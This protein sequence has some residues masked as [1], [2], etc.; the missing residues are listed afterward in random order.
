MPAKTPKN[1]PATNA[2][3]TNPLDALDQFQ[4]DCELELLRT[5][6]RYARDDY[7]ASWA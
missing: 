1:A 2:D 4:E 5:S 7:N 6:P 3:E